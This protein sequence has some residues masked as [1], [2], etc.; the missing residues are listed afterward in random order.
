MTESLLKAPDDTQAARRVTLNAQYDE[1][2]YERG[3]VVGKSSYMNYSWMPEL[4]IRMAHFLILNLSIAKDDRVLDYGCAKGY[5]VR[6]LRLLGVDAE[7]VDVS[8]Y[9]IDNVDG[10][11]KAHC[12]LIDDPADGRLFQGHYD[13]MI[14]KDVFEHVMQDDLRALLG[15]ASSRCKRMF[16]AVPLAADDHCNSFI[17]PEYNKDI[18]HITIKSAAWWTKLFEDTGWDIDHFSHSFPGVKENWTGV[19]ADG[20]AFYCISSRKQP[21]AGLGPWPGGTPRGK[22]FKS[23]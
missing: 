23:D 13:M 11:V 18:T 4:T 2:Y 3:V 16:V 21:P 20:N 5:L 9:A 1:D 19:W 14:A 6:A 10:S 12:R 17:V 15:R 8:R 7:G 22:S